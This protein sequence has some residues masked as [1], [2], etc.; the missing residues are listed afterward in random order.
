MVIG[1]IE[2][3]EGLAEFVRDVD[4]LVTETTFLQRDDALARAYG[5]SPQPRPLFLASLRLE[6][7]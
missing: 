6:S 5:N 1:D 4:V 7:A 3:I 2:T